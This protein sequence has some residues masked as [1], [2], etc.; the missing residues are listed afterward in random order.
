MFKKTLRA[1]LPLLLSLIFVGLSWGQS[2][3]LVTY[4]AVACDAN[5]SELTDQSIGVRFTII[6]DAPNGS[7]LYLEEHDITTDEFGL[8]VANIGDGGVSTTG[9]FTS[10]DWSAGTFFLKVELDVDGN[11]SYSTLANSQILSVPYAF[12]SDHAATSDS[13]LRAAIAD[14]T[15]NDFDRDPV[16]EIQNL[17]YTDGVLSISGGNS[18]ALSVDDADSDPRNEIQTLSF[19]GDS[20]KLTAPDG[21]SNGFRLYDGYFSSPG[22]DFSF[23]QGLIGQYVTIVDA[24]Y[25][26]PMGKVLYLT[27]ATRSID[28]PA[29]SDVFF[30]APSM[31]VFAPGTIL[32]DCQC[33]GFLV[34]DEPKI[35]EIIIDF[36]S[37]STYVVPNGK[38]LVIKSGFNSLEN[39]ELVINDVSIRYESPNAI[40]STMALIFEE[41][42]R[43]ELFSP[44]RGRL[45]TG[46]L[47]NN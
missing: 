39:L 42:T 36:N 6:K 28:A 19:D 20:L 5:G 26:V 13:S 43:I 10:I 22:A 34:D 38:T 25:T 41:T 8:F 30:V 45:Y 18:F 37:I 14:S 33:S 2:P 21:S 24:N 29:Y 23:P 27:A 15:L 1:G 7:P 46:Y 31:P 11:G 16:N 17:D 47:L 4:Q 40:K 9:D 12:Y 3:Q 44:D 35:Q 32:R